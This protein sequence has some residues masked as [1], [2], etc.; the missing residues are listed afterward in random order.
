MKLACFVDTS[1]VPI[2]WPLH[3]ATSMSRPAESPVGLVKTEPGVLPAGLV[4]A[5]PP[6]DLAQLGLTGLTVAVGQVEG[7]LDDDLVGTDRRPPVPEVA[8]HHGHHDI[9]TGAQINHAD[10]PQ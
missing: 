8:L 2:R 7:R 6:H 1:A 3:P 5:T 4:V 9:L 10:L